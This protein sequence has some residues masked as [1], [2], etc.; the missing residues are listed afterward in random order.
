MIAVSLWHYRAAA[1]FAD[2]APLG[3]PVGDALHIAIAFEA[4]L[5]NATVNRKL[6]EAGNAL[7]VPTELL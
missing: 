7:G 3:L 6:A 2:Q 5:S 1:Q 4:G